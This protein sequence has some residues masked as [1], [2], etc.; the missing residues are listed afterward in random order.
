MIHANKNGIIA[1]ERDYGGDL[2]P[3]FYATIGKTLPAKCVMHGKLPI[4]D[5]MLARQAEN[6]LLQ[7]GKDESNRLRLRL[8][9]YLK[10]YI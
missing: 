5:L 2:L 9:N 1:S 8:V 6:D 4:Q 10:A 7:Q 3:F